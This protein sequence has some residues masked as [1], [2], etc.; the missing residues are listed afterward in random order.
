MANPVVKKIIKKMIKKAVKEPVKAGRKR[1]KRGPKAKKKVESA[2]T[3][4]KKATSKAIRKNTPKANRGEVQKLAK[5]QRNEM[6]E[7]SGMGG[8]K[9][10]RGIN[11]DP[12]S[13]HKL[14]DE[15]MSSWN[16]YEKAEQKRKPH[17]EPARSVGESMRGGGY[18]AEEIE[19]LLT[20]TIVNKKGGGPIVRGWGK[21][22]RKG[23]K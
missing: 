10:G 22:R 7:D 23:S 13:Q 14:S 9:G 21:A 11:E 19:E 18:S 5:Q 2:A 3:T 6:L 20:N 15:D 4:K 17:A 1:K 16:K 8:K 12:K